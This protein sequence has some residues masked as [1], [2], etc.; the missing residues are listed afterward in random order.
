MFECLVLYLND[1]CLTFKVALYFHSRSKPPV[2][3][4]LLVEI[5]M[6]YLHLS[7]ESY[8]KHKA[9]KYIGVYGGLIH[10]LLRS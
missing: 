2:D 5:Y 4:E 8:P 9:Q 1:P 10:E 3:Y 6:L 7:I